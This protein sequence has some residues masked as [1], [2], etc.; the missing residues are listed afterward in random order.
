MIMH[1]MSCLVSSKKDAHSVAKFEKALYSLV[2]N[3]KDAEA[4]KELDWQF[5]ISGFSL[6]SAR[7]KQ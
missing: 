6:V 1:E 3:P 7:T 4:K 2:A 5:E